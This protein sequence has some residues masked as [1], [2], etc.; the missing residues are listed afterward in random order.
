MR[1][2]LKSVV[3]PLLLRRRRIR[4]KHS[5][6]LTFDDGPDPA[7]TPQVLERLRA[8]DARAVFFVVGNRI[9]KA[10]DLLEKIVA[11]GHVLGNHSY[12][13]WLDK[14]PGPIEYYRDVRRCQATLAEMTGRAPK[15]YRAPLGRRT[16]SSVAVPLLLGM[17]HVLWSQDENDWSL[18]GAAAAKSV[19]ERLASKVAPG[20]IVLL[21][22]D[23]P[24]VVTVLDVMLPHLKRRG[25]D[26]ATGVD[27]LR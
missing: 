21:H 5:V 20:D 10:P 7:V 19:G 18:R 13:H 12:S 17:R 2:L 4:G 9:S 23:N 14:E 24:W 27:A 16:V 8:V 25:F 3:D 11:E 6:L 1:N 15:L 26:L 22:D